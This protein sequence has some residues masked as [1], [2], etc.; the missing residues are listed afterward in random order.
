M[1]TYSFNDSELAELKGKTILIIGAASGIGYETVKLAHSNGAN[2]AIGDWNQTE[3][4]AFAAELK[5]RVLFR[6]C[7]VSS[8]DDV[9][10]LF[11]AA[12]KAF[13][14]IHAVLSNAGINKEDIFRD[15]IDSKTGKLLPPDLKLLDVNLTGMVYAVK[16]AVHYFAKWPDTRC[17]IVLT[18]SA[19]SFLDTPPLHLYCASK[20]GVLGFMRSLRSQLVN[21]NI[22][23]NM[24]APWMTATAMTKDLDGIWQREWG[25]P[26]N[27]PDGVGRALLLPV[28]RTNVNGKSFFVA[29]N[30]ITEFEDK[31]HESQPIWMGEELSKNVDEGQRR[32]L[33]GNAPWT[34]NC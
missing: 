4:Q 31:I 15:E 17:Q 13:G 23:V 9:L 21:R 8:W 29:G 3:G 11:Q 14:V 33:P 12:W 24:V 25:L 19:A 5:E 6:R 20:A 2:V 26:A 18:G 32:L 10:E 34:E 1:T 27:M 22:T 16:C 7:D 30:N 28:V